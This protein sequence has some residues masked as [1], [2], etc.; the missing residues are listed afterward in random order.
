ME[1]DKSLALTRRDAAAVSEESIASEVH[2]ASEESAASEEPTRRTLTRR[3]FVRVGATAALT[4]AALPAAGALSSCRSDA[5]D[6]FFRN[7]R[8]IVDHAGRE[9]TIPTADTITKVYF[10]SGLAQVYVF[11]LKPEVQGGTSG[12]FTKEQLEYLP[13]GINELPYMGS[14]SDGGEI[15]REQLLAEGIQLVFSISGVGLT[16]A[17]ISD[18]EG[19]Q[20]ATDIPVVLVDGSFDIIGDAYRFVGDILGVQDRAE[21]IAQYLEGIYHDV[22]TALEPVSDDERVSLYYAEGAFGLNTE[23]NVSQH[24]SCFEAAKA[25]NVAEVELTVDLGMTSVSLE[26]VYKWDPEVIVAWDAQVLGG[27]DE[28][29]RTDEKWANIQAVKNGRVYT[30]PSTPFSW[31]DRPPG[32]N[33]MLGLQWVANMLYPDLYD[34]DMVEETK[35]FYSTLYWVDITDD[36]ALDMLGNSY[37]PYSKS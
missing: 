22:T 29:I 28:L 35:K 20:A 10:T 27:A 31:C 30:M 16:A 34:V 9:L 6:E 33:R 13:E 12:R 3:D 5:G 2:A 8:K 24:A 4:A 15:D 36:Q 14:L 32:V 1:A 19:L 26:S 18:A 17:N 11:S 25:K 7:K 37:P 21:T 23:P